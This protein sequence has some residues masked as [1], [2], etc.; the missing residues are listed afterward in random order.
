[1]YSRSSFNIS[2]QML[3]FIAV[4]KKIS[5][6]KHR[7]DDI[8]TGLKTRQKRNKKQTQNNDERVAYIN[9]GAEVSVRPFISR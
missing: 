6:H 9:N 7:S 1:M 5:Q 2:D 4:Q 3:S 8:S